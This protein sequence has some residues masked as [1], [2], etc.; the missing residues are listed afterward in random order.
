MKCVERGK[1]G[2]GENFVDCGSEQ[3]AGGGGRSRN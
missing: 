3:G 2:G 1:G